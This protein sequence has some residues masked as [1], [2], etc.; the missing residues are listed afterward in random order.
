MSDKLNIKDWDSQDRPRE[1]M[2]AK[3]ADA[4]TDAELLAILIRSGTVGY[5]ALEVGQSLLRSANGDLNQLARMSHK[6]M[7]KTKGLGETKA[8]GIAAALELG[9]RRQ[10]TDGNEKRK[11]TS[12]RDAYDIIGTALYDLLHE[13]FWAIFLDRA[14][15]VIRMTKISQ[16]GIAGTVVDP[17]LIFK[18]AL[19]NLASGI[20]LVHNHPSG[21]LRPSQADIDITR[22]LKIAGTTLEIPILDHLIIAG[23]SYF[24]FAD[25]GM[26]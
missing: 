2:M 18:P 21:N 25:D 6:D 1:K 11:I 20:I 9:R 24:S 16:G 17:R 3:G 12:S 7:M 19:E 15:Q 13:E 5:N 26:M 10:R 4:L 23:K 14:N 8:I 22:K